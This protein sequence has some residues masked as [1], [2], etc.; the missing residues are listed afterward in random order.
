MRGRYYV[1]NGFAAN[2]KEDEK[3]IDALVPKNFQGNAV[4]QLTRQ[5][6]ILNETLGVLISPEGKRIADFTMV[7]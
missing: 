4:E 5:G 6:Y 3:R 7:I 2:C 1:M